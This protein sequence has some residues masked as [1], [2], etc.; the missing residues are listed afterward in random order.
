MAIDPATGTIGGTP[1]QSGTFD[2]TVTATDI[3]GA[4]ASKIFL[5]VTFRPTPLITGPNTLPDG[6][7]SVVYPSTLITFS[8]GTA[9]LAWS[10]TGLPPGLTINAGTGII[11]GTPSAAGHSQ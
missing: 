11:S 2:V 9:P 5:S 4:S 8:G 10:A 1:T 7:I 3:A 6:L